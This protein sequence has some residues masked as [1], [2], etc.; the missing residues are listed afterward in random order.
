[1]P[2]D[3]AVLDF[4]RDNISNP[5]FDFIMP[6]ITYLG[7]GGIIWII[8][9]VVMLIIKKYR[10]TGLKIACALLLS[11]IICNILLKPTVARIRPFDINTAIE[12]IISKPTDY[13]FP[14]GHTTASFAAAMV[15]VLSESKR[16]W[17]PAVIIAILIS[18]SRLYLYVHFP[19]DVL[20]GMVLGTV[21][22]YLS[23]RLIDMIFKKKMKK[24]GI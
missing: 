20:C 5:F 10:R 12:L 22:A 6:K 21:L 18:F 9:A 23:S 8:T 4:I 13:S 1:M 15:L 19:T 2:F 7:S 24:S 11:L 17:I 16:I 14:S 3:F